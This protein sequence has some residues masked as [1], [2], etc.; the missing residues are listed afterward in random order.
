MDNAS[1]DGTA[2]MV[3]RDFAEV[4]LIET[5]ANQGMVAYNL[6]F[7]AAQGDYILVMDDDGLPARDDW[8]AQ[9]VARFEANPRLGAISCT[10]RMRDTGKIAHDSPQFVPEGNDGA[11]YPGVAFN[12]T[13]AGLRTAALRGAGYYP[14]HFFRTYLELHLCTRLLGQ[15]WHVLHFPELEVW[16]CRQSQSAQERPYTYFGLR[17]YYWYIWELYPRPQVLGETFHE[18]GSRFKLL[19][20]GRI[21]VSLFWRATRDAFLGM[22]KALALRHPVSTDTIGHMRRVRRHGNW[23]GLTPEIRPFDVDLPQTQ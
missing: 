1:T 9:I 23:H 20:G 7:E 17:N 18:L 5:S 16:H 14:W 11:G 10:I 22:R 3:R 4:R 19:L 12:G 6:G 21:P 2:E 8:I 15:G 13:G